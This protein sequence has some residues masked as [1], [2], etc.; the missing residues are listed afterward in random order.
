M[1]IPID[2]TIT[3]FTNLIYKFNLSNITDDLN[4]NYNPSLAFSKL[5]CHTYVKKNETNTCYFIK[6][7][8]IQPEKIEI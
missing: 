5:F 8:P 4:T 3:Y 6:G 7:C 2:D 1:L